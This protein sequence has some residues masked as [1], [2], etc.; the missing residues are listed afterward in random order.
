MISPDV[1]TKTPEGFFPVD[2][3]DVLPPS[4]AL[5]LLLIRPQV[6]LSLS[7]EWRV[8]IFSLSVRHEPDLSPPFL[9]RVFHV[10]GSPCPAAA[11]VLAGSPLGA[12][13]LEGPMAQ[14]SCSQ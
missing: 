4:R 1:Q 14:D 11:V 13:R 9:S 5:L 10:V 12:Y 7:P 6:W 2:T 8:P 3:P